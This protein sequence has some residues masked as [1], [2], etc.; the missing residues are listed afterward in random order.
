MCHVFFGSPA[1][2]HGNFLGSMTHDIGLSASQARTLP[3]VFH[4]L[5]AVAMWSIL[6]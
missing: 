6:G 1:R 2:H 4:W 5:V 3:E